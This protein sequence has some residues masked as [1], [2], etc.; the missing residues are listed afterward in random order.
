M[1]DQYKILLIALFFIVITIEGSAVERGERIDSLVTITHKSI[2]TPNIFKSL[3]TTLRLK[4]IE[5]ER[6]ISYKYARVGVPKV[7][8]P[9]GQWFFGG[10]VM[11]SNHDNANYKFL[12]I[13]GWS[14][15]GDRTSVSVYGGKTVKDNLSI[16]LKGGY[17]KS[18]LDLD[19]LNISIMEG[20]EFNL[21][22]MYYI[23]Q[24]I[25]VTLFMRNFLPILGDRRFGLFNDTELNI[26]YG[27]GKS[28]TKAGDVV[29]GTYT[30]TVKSSLGI[31]P[32]LMLFL[33]D[34]AAF[35][36]SV[37]LIGFK[38]QT[39]TQVT[40]Q[41]ETGTRN[42]SGIKFGVNLFSIRLGVTFYLNGRKWAARNREIENSYD[43][44]R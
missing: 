27:Q 9:K 21:K 6:K 43:M 18:V 19:G 5:V 14:G 2:V 11:F 1:K 38:T 32:G 26:S 41:I 12:V 4:P 15:S 36:V 40:N 35:E 28:T 24:E 31:S 7:F 25:D 16:G 30:T 13:D 29:S 10:S 3:D 37:G 8:V 22:D 20:V 44:Y 42:T 23:N 17:T 34:M 33:Q 39:I